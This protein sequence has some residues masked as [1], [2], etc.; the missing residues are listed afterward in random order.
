MHLTTFNGREEIRILVSSAANRPE[1]CETRSM[2]LSVPPAVSTAAISVSLGELV[3]W[4]GL[5]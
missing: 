3:R 2:R 1:S 4:F 5:R